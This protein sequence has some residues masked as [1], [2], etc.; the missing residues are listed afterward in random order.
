MVESY[1]FNFPMI[2][3]V[4]YPAFISVHFSYFAESLNN[5]CVRRI[6]AAGVRR[7]A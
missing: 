3:P 5:L 7:V 4:F 1:N 2:L 6:S